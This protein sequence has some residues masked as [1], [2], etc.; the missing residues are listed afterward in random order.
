MQLIVM[1]EISHVWSGFKQPHLMEGIPAHGTGAW[2]LMVFNVSSSQNQ[3]MIVWFSE[4][5]ALLL[6]LACLEES[7]DTVFL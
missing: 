4:V 1:L 2:N 7:K 5:I 3:S 6:R